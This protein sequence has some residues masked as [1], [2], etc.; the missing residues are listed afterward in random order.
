MD[1]QMPLMDGLATTAVIRA[2]EQGQAP[3][4]DLPEELAASLRQRLA[5]GHV[6][7]VAMT[8]H[9]MGGDRE[10]CLQAGMDGYVTKPFQ[11]TDLAIVFLSLTSGASMPTVHE[12]RS[13]VSTAPQTGSAS[14]QPTLRAMT[15]HL[16]TST[17][18][19]PSQVE[20]VLAAARTSITDNLHGALQALS[21]GDRVALGRYAHTLKGTLLQCG[22]L[23]LAAVAETIQ[24]SV[25]S[26]EEQ[27]YQ[28]LLEH[29]H[30]GLA[31]VILP[32]C[33][34]AVNDQQEG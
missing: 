7:I 32:T 20:R 17:N 18:L 26:G 31:E 29:L 33:E 9:A 22:L 15:D 28:E 4:R 14:I 12:T 27:P 21:A 34:D 8:A 24:A 5:S 23:E 19:N 3:D 30:T 10:M 13:A 25:R 6:P 11:P 16:Q 1:V 2:F